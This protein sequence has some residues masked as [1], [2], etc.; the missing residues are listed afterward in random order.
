[1][2]SYTSNNQIIDTYK[3]IALRDSCNSVRSIAMEQLYNNADDT[4]IP[5][6]ALIASNDENETIRNTAQKYLDE[7]VKNINQANNK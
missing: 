1:L 6:L 2:A 5:I 3:T 7:I 4:V